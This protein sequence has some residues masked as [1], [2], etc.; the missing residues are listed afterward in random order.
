M[1]SNGVNYFYLLH[2]DPV[3]LLEALRSLSAPDPA[4]ADALWA[5][6]MRLT[7]SKRPRRLK[8]LLTAGWAPPHDAYWRVLRRS[9]SDLPAYIRAATLGGI[10]VPWD[11]RSICRT[12]VADLAAAW[13]ENQ[14]GPQARAIAQAMGVFQQPPASWPTAL[15]ALCEHAVA[16]ARVIPVETQPR[17]IL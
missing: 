14:A 15:R 13:L 9:G 17:G 4:L 8:A 16:H 3:G 11:A 6:S 2:H 7:A 1:S 5:Q 10:Q 12:G